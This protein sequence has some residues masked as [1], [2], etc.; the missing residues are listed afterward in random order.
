MSSAH[1]HKRRM[2]HLLIPVLLA[3]LLLAAPSQGLAQNP[4]ETGG[5]AQLVLPDL[6]QGTFLGTS[7]RT[8]L[9][10]GLGVC[11]LGLLVGFITYTRLRNLPVHSSMREGSELSGETCKT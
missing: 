5:E 11:A 1:V 8:L 4:T 3:I 9:M 10:L 7:G 2:I 6:N